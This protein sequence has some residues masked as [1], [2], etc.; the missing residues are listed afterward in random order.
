MP[1]REL[2]H[3][4][5]IMSATPQPSRL[6]YLMRDALVMK[7]RAEVSSGVAQLSVYFERPVGDSDDHI[8]KMDTI[9]AKI[10]LAQQKLAALDRVVPTSPPEPGESEQSD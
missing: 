5:P 9:V 6:P 4:E 7:Y 1:H 8:E 3:R 2:P 10:A